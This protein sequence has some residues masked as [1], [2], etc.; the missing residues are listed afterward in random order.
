MTQAVTSRSPLNGGTALVEVFQLQGMIRKAEGGENGRPH[1]E[2]VSSKDRGVK[3][4]RS[5]GARCAD[6]DAGGA[7][8]EGLSAAAGSTAARRGRTSRTYDLEVACSEDWRSRIEELRRLRPPR[9]RSRGPGDSLM[10][11]PGESELITLARRAC[12]DG[13]EASWEAL[14]VPLRPPRTAAVAAAVRSL[15]G[16]EAVVILST[17][18][19]RYQLHPRERAL[20]TVWILQVLENRGGILIGRRELEESLRDLRLHLE[21]SSSGQPPLCSEVHQC[22][23]RWHLIRQ[24]ADRLRRSCPS[25][26]GEAAVS[27]RGGKD[28]VGR[29]LGDTPT[30]TAASVQAEA[31]SESD[32]EDM[33]EACEGD[34]AKS[35]GDE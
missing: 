22:L 20:C 10:P 26:K 15:N 1:C 4:R 25:A 31:S 28:A 13:T 12:S 29:P 2:D 30:T 8:G 3:R 6:G 16:P 11:P 17:L 19:V 35:S 14:T 32:D 21:S 9:S 33:Q 27:S 24:F 5:R 23:G 7:N 34:D 18:A